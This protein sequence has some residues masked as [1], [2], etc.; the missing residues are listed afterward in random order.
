[1]ISFIVALF[2]GWPA[3]LVTLVLSVIGLLRGNPRFLVAAAIIAV[4]FSWALSGFPLVKTPVF[5]LPLLLFGAG[6]CL[7]RGSEMLAWLLV[8]PYFMTIWLL[9]NAI[10]Y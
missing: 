9:V 3:I 7:Y 4:P 2:L 10:S 5:L 1:M 8:I 6:Y